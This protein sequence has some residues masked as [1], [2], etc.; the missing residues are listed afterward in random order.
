[1]HNPVTSG[2]DLAGRS[3]AG[4]LGD[5]IHELGRSVGRIL[6][7]LDCIGAAQNTLDTLV[8]FA[9]DNGGVWKPEIE[10]LT[11][12]EAID[13]GLKVNADFRGGK[14]DLWAGG[15]HSPFSARWPRKGRPGSVTNATVSVVDILATA[16]EVVNES[17]NTNSTIFPMIEASGTTLSKRSP[18][19]FP[20]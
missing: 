18:T 5:W 11:Q 14:H 16:A 12:T 2:Q 4:P 3:A 15:F 20:G 13:A 19:T 10:R 1:V 8:F 17:L 7:T 6:E 9:S